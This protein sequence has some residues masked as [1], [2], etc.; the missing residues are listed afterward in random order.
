MAC[1]AALTGIEAIEKEG[2]PAHPLV[3]GRISRSAWL[4]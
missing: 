2:L 3:L 1:A 4:H